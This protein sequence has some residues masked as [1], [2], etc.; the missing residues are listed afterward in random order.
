MS[1]KLEAS[2]DHLIKTRE[3]GQKKSLRSMWRHDSLQEHLRTSMDLAKK[4]EKGTAEVRVKARH[5]VRL[6]Y[7][8]AFKAKNPRVF[9]GLGFP[10]G[11]KTCHTARRTNAERRQPRS[12]IHVVP[13]L[14]KQKA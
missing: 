11:R 10:H 3:G 9:V 2:L 7:A 14:R 4:R 6:S 12:T 1:G 13:P 8:E 5:L